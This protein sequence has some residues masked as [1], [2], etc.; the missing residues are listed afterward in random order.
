M[1]IS[2]SGIIPGESPGRFA[3]ILINQRQTEKKKEKGKKNPNK[4]ENYFFF[5]SQRFWF[6]ILT[7]PQVML[8]SNKQN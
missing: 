4:T 2:P 3:S 7:V 6:Q 1:I 8:D 5:A